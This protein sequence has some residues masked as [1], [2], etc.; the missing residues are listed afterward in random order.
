[1]IDPLAHAECLE[2]IRAAIA[3]NDLQTARDIASVI[4]EVCGIGPNQP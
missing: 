3:S 2:F 1:M 4:K